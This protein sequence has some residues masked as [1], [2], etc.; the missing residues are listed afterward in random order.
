M[1]FQTSVRNHLLVL[2][3]WKLFAATLKRIC[4]DSLTDVLYSV[5]CTVVEA[6]WRASNQKMYVV[7]PRKTLHHAVIW[8]RHHTWKYIHNRE[9]TGKIWKG[10]SVIPEYCRH[11]TW[12][13]HVKSYIGSRS[14]CGLTV[15]HIYKWRYI[16][17][18]GA[19]G[20]VRNGNWK[21]ETEM[22]TEMEMQPFSCCSPSK[23]HVLF[24]FLCIPEP[25]PPPVF[26]CLLC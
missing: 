22:K 25:S 4:N 11:C 26:N 8:N 9:K 20:K 17:L 24:A 23:I 3:R 10:C 13:Y 19:Y 14:L 5:L 16:G 15:R 6:H 12:K 18:F 7:Y 2:R 1:H 21:R